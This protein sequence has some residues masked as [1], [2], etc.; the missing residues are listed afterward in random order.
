MRH[1]S[2]PIIERLP[3]IGIKDIVDK[4]RR[5]NPHAVYCLDSFGLRFGGG[6]VRVCNYALEVTPTNGYKQVF[7]TKW[8]KTYFGRHRPLFVCSCC[9]LNYQILF[10]YHGRWACRRCHKAEYLSQHLCSTRQKL[11]QAARLRIQLNGLPTDYKLPPRPRGRHRKRYLRLT[12]RIASLEQKAR[13]ARKREFDTRTFAY[14]L[15]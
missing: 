14:H 5:D 11:W 10:E 8:V 13:K 9:R 1:S 6:R 15:T 2:R 4:I 7:R 12:D 3:H